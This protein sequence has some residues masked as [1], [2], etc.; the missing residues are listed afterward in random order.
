MSISEAKRKEVFLAYEMNGEPIQPQHGYPLRLL[1]PGWY[2][3]TSVKWLH[4]IEAVVKP[5]QG[6]QMLKAY[7]YSKAADDPGEPVNLIR[8]RALMIPPGIPDFMT[9]QRLV[10]AGR[11]TLSGKAWAGRTGISRVQVSVDGCAR[12]SEAQV[13]KPLSAYAW[14]PW[15]F[16]WNAT[17]GNYVLCARAT[18]AAGNVQPLD[19]QWN[20]G[21]YGNNAV[22]RVNVLV[23]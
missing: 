4:Q 8:V 17:P 15:T 12:W 2:G 22:Q 1:V 10:E 11:V 13:D 20:F 23:E 9:R 19:Q 16:V 7:R 5:F 21:G 14:T 6:Y 3:M 18:D